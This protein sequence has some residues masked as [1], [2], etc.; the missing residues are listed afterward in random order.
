VRSQTPNM[1]DRPAKVATLGLWIPSVAFAH[2]EEALVLLF[3][4]IVVIA[5]CLA[6]SYFLLRRQGS[7][8][9]AVI[10][11][12]VGVAIAWAVTANLPFRDNQA[13]IAFLHLV[14]PMLA[15]ALAITVVRRLR[16]LAP[17]SALQRTREDQR[18]AERKR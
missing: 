14:L 5:G 11:C 2:G 13:L 10:S 3:G 8:W 18:A 15:T 16:P 4:E 1:F 6:A 12:F 9:V 7:A 17:N